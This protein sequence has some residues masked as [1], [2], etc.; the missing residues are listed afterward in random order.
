MSGAAKTHILR[1]K[2]PWRRDGNRTRARRPGGRPPGGIPAG[3]AG[4]GRAHGTRWHRQPA[5]GILEGSAPVKIRLWGTDEEC[6]L[7]AERL[8][9]TPGLLVLS[10]SEPRPDRGASVLV[11]VYV[12]ARLDTQPSNGTTYLS[13]RSGPLASGTTT[14]AASALR[15]SEKSSA[16]Q[17]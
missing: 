11:R 13:A 17:A 5:G 16:R 2:P 3:D 6:R 9:R 14:A 15:I 8:M 7:A 4:R 1:V 10:I 12:E